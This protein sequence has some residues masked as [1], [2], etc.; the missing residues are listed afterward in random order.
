M[1]SKSQGNVIR[2][3]RAFGVALPPRTIEASSANSFGLQLGRRGCPSLLS[4][5]IGYETESPE[6]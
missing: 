2:L 3:E 5:K 4:V 6:S 1:G